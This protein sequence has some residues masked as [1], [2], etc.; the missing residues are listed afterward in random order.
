MREAGSVWA[1]TSQVAR[2]AAKD[3]QRRGFWRA[4]WLLRCSIVLITTLRLPR[5][6][7]PSIASAWRTPPARRGLTTRSLPDA[8]R[9]TQS[10]SPARSSRPSRTAKDHRPDHAR[11]WHASRGRGAGPGS[12]GQGWATR[13]RLK[14]LVSGRAPGPDWLSAVPLGPSQSGLRLR[15]IIEIPGSNDQ[16]PRDWHWSGKRILD[17]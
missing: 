4:S 10:A 9:R 6:S 7:L 8:M 13:R 16:A 14:P 2:L 15:S 1:G 12:D 3:I 11:H 17:V 5:R